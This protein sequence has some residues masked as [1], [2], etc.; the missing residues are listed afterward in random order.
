MFDVA[1]VAPKS[2]DLLRQ[3][4]INSVPLGATF[5]PRTRTRR[6]RRARCRARRRCRP[7]CSGPTR[8]RRHPHVGLQRL[9]QLPL[10]ADGHEPPVRRGVHVLVLLR[11]EQGARHQ[12]RRLRGRP[13][14]RDRRR[15]R[16]LDYSYA[17][18]TGRTT[19]SSTS[20]TSCRSSRAGRARPRSSNDWQFPA[21][22]AGRAAG[23]TGVGYSIPA[24]TREP[25]RHRRQPGRAIVADVRPGHGLRATTRIAVQHSCFAPPQPGSDGAE[26]ARFFL[27]ARRSTTS[28]CRSRRSS[29]VRKS[30][31]FEFRVDAFNALNHTQ[32]TGVNST[33]NFA[34]LTNPTITNLPTT[35]R[36]LR[37]R[38]GFGAVNGVA[39]PRTLQIV[40]RLTF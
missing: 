32:F 25:D 34:S 16:R 2:D 35:Q 40:T 28:T 18:T 38:N 15:D 8:L 10:A 5:L 20:S 24:S 21:S 31:R 14:E 27:R 30:L 19:S 22:T 29:L 1:Y 6:A 12:Q 36:E 9:R 4:Q 7:T 13:A 11:V 26:S 37:Q 3:V 33:A 17:T 39:P 23:R